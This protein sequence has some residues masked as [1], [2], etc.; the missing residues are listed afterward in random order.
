[1][2]RAAT[3]ADFNNQSRY[4][5]LKLEIYFD[6]IGSTPLTITKSDYL[7]DANWLEEISADSGNPFGV[8]SSNELTFRLLNLNGMFSPT[9]TASVYYGKIKS[10]VPVKLFIRPIYP[11]DDVEWTQLGL[12]YV[13][14]WDAQLTG[15]YADVTANDIWYYI[16]NGPMINYPVTND[17]SYRN[18]LLQV[19][20]LLGYTVNVDVALSTIL[21]YAYVNESTKEFIKSIVAAAIAYATCDKTGQPIIEALTKERITRA[22]LTDSNQIK[23][24]SA[25]QSINKAYD[26]VA[27]SYV[28]PTMSGIENLVSV[29]DLTVPVGTTTIEGI[30]YT[31]SPVWDIVSVLLEDTNSTVKLVSYESTQDS[32]TVVVDNQGTAEANINVYA[33]GKYIK[34]TSIALADAGSSLLKFDNNFIQTVE[35]ATAVKGVLQKYAS[36]DAPS[37]TVSIRGNPLLS[38]GDKIVISSVKYNI[39]FTGL[40]QRLDYTY[41]GGLSCTLTVVNAAIFE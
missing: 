31:S 25:K 27:I 23:T 30:K 8:V 33:Y 22:I 11:A 19:F 32:L 40:I 37:L 2:A 14:G 26:G 6:G 18:L 21:P 4:L 1:M 12:Y 9:N 28:I 17:V 5:E 36:Q 10:G 3:D 41:D 13:T 7:I 35:Y 16:L 38:L 15:T 24:V 34:F 20:T 29:T 39:N